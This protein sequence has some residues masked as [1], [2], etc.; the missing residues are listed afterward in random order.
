MDFEF[1][2]LD[3]LQSIRTPVGDAII[4]LLTYLGEF[5]AIWIILAIVL[6]INRKYR[7]VGLIV[8][9]AL[10]L[11][12]IICNGILKN[13]FQRTRPCDINTSI[14]LLVPHPS[15]YSFPSGHTAA[16]FAAASALLFAKKYKWSIYA[17]I[18]AAIIAFTR[19]YLYVHFP[20]DILGGMAA[21]FLAGFLA[22]V[23]VNA[24]SKKVAPSCQK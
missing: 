24:V 23:V 21:G 8:A 4:P 19:L 11:D 1:K 17:Y 12:L 14:K 7:K 5:G 20:T 15:E 22:N 2:I 16:S 13:I 10:I 9:V 6:L 18:L 3:F